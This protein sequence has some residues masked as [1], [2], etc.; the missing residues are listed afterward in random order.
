MGKRLPQGIPTEY[1]EQC[2]VIRWARMM[3]ETGQE[4]RLALLHGDASGVRVGIGAAVK[5]RKAGAVKGW[6]DLFLPVPTEPL[7]GK[8]SG[9]PGIWDCCGLFIEL[10]RQN[11]GTVSPE[12]K[13]IQVMLREQGYWVQ[14]CRGADEA[15]EAI[16][17]YLVI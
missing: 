13:N 6:P 16:K 2:A 11:G 12:Q 10:K 9:C 3:A 17:K 1:E 7:D 4:P 8:D 14:V 15:I 5:M